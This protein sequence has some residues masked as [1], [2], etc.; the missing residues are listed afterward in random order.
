[1]EGETDYR[2]QNSAVSRKH[3]DIIK[4]QGQYFVMDL[5]STNGTYLGGRRIQ[6]GV[7]ELLSD[8]AIV[9]F[10]NAEYKVHID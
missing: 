5:G 6:T 10:A 2:I 3:A 9:R 8:G 1:M 7:K 4:E